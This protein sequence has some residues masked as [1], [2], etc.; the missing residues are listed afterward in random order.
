MRALADGRLGAFLDGAPDAM[1][2]VDASGRII[3]VNAQ[4]E[5]LFGY[6]QEELEGQLVEMLVPDAGRTVHPPHR[7]RYMADPKPRPMGGDAAVRSP[8]RWLRLSRGH[9]PVGHRH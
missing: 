2:W 5:G 3:M 1:L 7:A 6:Q 4:V 9:L 8:P